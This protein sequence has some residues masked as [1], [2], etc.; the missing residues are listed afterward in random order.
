MK[1]ALRSIIVI[2]VIWMAGLAMRST[3]AIGYSLL[4][5]VLPATLLSD[6]TAEERRHIA[7]RLRGLQA[8]GYLSWIGP[9]SI[10]LLSGFALWSAN[11]LDHTRTQEQRSHGTPTP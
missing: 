6:T 5:H 8:P 2:C 11:R 4:D 3:T 9:V 10:L 1:N 7:D